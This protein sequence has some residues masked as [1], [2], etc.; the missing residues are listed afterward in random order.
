MSRTLTLLILW[1]GL[2]LPFTASAA[3][4]LSP[5]AYISVLTCDTGNELYS[6]FGHT[7][8]RVSDPRLG[9]D[10]VYNFGAFDFST[11]NFYL[12]FVKG[13]LQY[14]VTTAS[15]GEFLYEYRYLGRSVYEQLLNLSPSQK[16]F[17][18]DRLESVLGSNERYYTYKFIDRNCTTMV[19]DILVSATGKPLSL[20]VNGKG[21]TNRKILYGYLQQQFY[22][23]LGISIMFGAKTDREL[24]KVYLPMQ[25]MESLSKSKNGSIPLSRPSVTVYEA[26]QTKAAGSW[27]D[28]VY[29][30]AG[31]LLLLAFVRNRTVLLTWWTVG[32]LLG[33]FL[34]LVGLYSYHAEVAWNYNALLFSPFFACLVVSLLLG[35]K[36]HIRLWWYA[37]VACQVVYLLYMLNKPHLLLLTPIILVNVLY[38]F[39]VYKSDVYCPR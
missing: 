33:T 28:N 21:E 13:D 38:L 25:L 36:K 1:L 27:W 39:R 10:T 4:R 9:I 5:D 7:A 8:I 35:K 12:K 19:A 34:A 32:A 3:K 15:Y 6:L 29:T 17:V 24:Y 30:Y 20:D 11:P 37:C 31:L 18:F 26:P 2:L 23:N 22:A 16:Q 14:F